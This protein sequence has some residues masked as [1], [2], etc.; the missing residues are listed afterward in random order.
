MPTVNPE[1]R[2]ITAKFKEEKGTK[3]TETASSASAIEPIPT[4]RTN[5]ILKYAVARPPIAAPRR[6]QRKSGA[7]DALS[8]LCTVERTC[9]M[10]N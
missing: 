5:G 7:A 9:E 10:F 3:T 1:K 4:R 2:K 6:M 8:T